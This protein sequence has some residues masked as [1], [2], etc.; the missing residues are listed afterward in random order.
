M[1]QSNHNPI[2]PILAGAAIGALAVDFWQ[3]H[4]EGESRKSQAEVDEPETVAEILE[5]THSL[6]DRIW[7]PENLRNENQYRDFLSKLLE[8]SLRYSIEIEPFSFGMKPDILIDGLVAI[9]LKLSPSKSEIDRLVGQVTGYARQWTTVI[10]LIDTPQSTVR[11]LE[12]LLRDARLD[13]V[14]IVEFSDT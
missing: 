12:G 4:I 7:L 14:D 13:H 5:E 8:R 3:D 2:L 9:E 11:R 6:L 10:F 1:E